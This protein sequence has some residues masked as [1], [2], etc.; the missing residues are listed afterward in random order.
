MENNREKTIESK[1]MKSAGADLK[2]CPFCGSRDLLIASVCGD[3]AVVCKGCGAQS[4]WHGGIDLE[5][6]EADAKAAWNRR[7]KEGG[8]E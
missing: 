6:A 8:A 3:K 5:K 1:W 4:D 2:P 7:V